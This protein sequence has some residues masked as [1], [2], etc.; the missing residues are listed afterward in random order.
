MYSLMAGPPF[1]RQVEVVGEVKPSFSS[2][3]GS[4]RAEV[5]LNRVVGVQG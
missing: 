2:L 3:I 5:G 1:L 4:S